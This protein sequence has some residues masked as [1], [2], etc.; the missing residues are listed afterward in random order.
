[1]LG[2][3]LILARDA[4]LSTQLRTDEGQGDL[5]GVEDSEEES[6]FTMINKDRM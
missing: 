2:L 5:A 3:R 4:G 1:M 6:F